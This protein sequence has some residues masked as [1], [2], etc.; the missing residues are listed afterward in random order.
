VLGPDHGLADGSPST[1]TATLGASPRRHD[2]AHQGDDGRRAAP[3]AALAPPGL[4][5]TRQAAR[6]PPQS[7][8]ETA[9]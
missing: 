4:A 5:V 6:P 8:P 7:E 2:A 9:V 1:R 3:L